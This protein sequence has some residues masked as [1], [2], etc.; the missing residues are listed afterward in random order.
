[1]LGD[2]VLK[3]AQHDTRVIVEDGLLN[4]HGQDTSICTLR[5]LSHVVGETEQGNIVEQL[6][7][8]LLRKG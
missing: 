7:V 8:A 2:V 4:R 6:R 5:E 1:M 3:L